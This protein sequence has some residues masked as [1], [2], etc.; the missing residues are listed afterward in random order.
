MK[1]NQIIQKRYGF[2]SNITTTLNPAH[3]DIQS[4][5]GHTHLKT[6]KPHTHLV[7]SKAHIQTH[8]LTLA[9][10][11]CMYVS[12]TFLAFS[13]TRHLSAEGKDTQHHQITWQ[14]FPPLQAFTGLA[15]FRSIH[16]SFSDCLVHAKK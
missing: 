16:C 8:K 13:T 2:Y 1:E 14:P 6:N 10:E 9:Y 4:P 3:T 12:L 5:G 11:A 7:S 15:Q